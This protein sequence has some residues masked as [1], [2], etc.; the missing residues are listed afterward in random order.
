MTRLFYLLLVS[1]FTLF[2]TA[3]S[4]SESTSE[5]DFRE[6]WVGTYEGTKSNRSFE[7]TMFTT[8]VEFE[9]VIDEASENGLIVNGINFPIDEDGSFGPGFLEETNSN[10]S[11]RIVAGELSLESFVVSSNIPGIS[12]PCFIIA[13]RE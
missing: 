9:V 3:C 8:E 12:L 4:D 11:L 1:V 10:F 6:Q 2:I 5:E 7:D 13:T